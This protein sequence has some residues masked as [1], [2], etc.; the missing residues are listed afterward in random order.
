[1]HLKIKYPPF[2]GAT[3]V[4]FDVEH[5]NTLDDSH[6]SS[7]HQIIYME[8]AVGASLDVVHIEFGMAMISKC[9]KYNC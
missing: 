7:D 3:T 8:A 5:Q 9:K 6:R 1:M 4:K 2:K